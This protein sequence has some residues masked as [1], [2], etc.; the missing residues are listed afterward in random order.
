MLGIMQYTG[1]H[2][3]KKV[4][5]EGRKK[6]TLL[7]CISNSTHE[8]LEPCISREKF[9]WVSL[10]EIDGVWLTERWGSVAYLQPYAERKSCVCIPGSW[11]KGCCRWQLKVHLVL[12]SGKNWRNLL[13][14]SE[15][16]VPVLTL[17][18]HNWDRWFRDHK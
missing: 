11:S 8:Q 14:T 13:L 9:Q 16:R 6:P 10:P 7:D 17:L 18:Q 4:W 2:V 3:Q 5:E 15:L 1:T 12:L